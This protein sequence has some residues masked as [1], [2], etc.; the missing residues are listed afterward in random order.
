MRWLP[1][2]V[3]S[4]TFFIRKSCLTPPACDIIFILFDYLSFRSE[5]RKSVRYSL[6]IVHCILYEPFIFMHKKQDDNQGQSAV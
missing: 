5:S 2:H 4:W 3:I 6:Q 1:Q